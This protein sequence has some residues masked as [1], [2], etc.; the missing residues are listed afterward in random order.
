[1]NDDPGMNNPKFA[2]DPNSKYYIPVKLTH[3]ELAF[4]MTLLDFLATPNTPIDVERK[5]N[6]SLARIGVYRREQES[7]LRGNIND[8]QLGIIMGILHLVHGK[9]PNPGEIEGHYFANAAKV[10]LYRRQQEQ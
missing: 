2:A 3:D 1:M 8:R 10:E 4:A 5:I 7:K 9:Q 6:M